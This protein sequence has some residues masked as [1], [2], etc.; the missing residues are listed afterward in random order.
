MTKRTRR[1]AD[2]TKRKKVLHDGDARQRP[3]TRSSGHCAS[4]PQQTT[5]NQHA[6]RTGVPPGWETSDQ[7]IFGVAHA[8]RKRGVVVGTASS[9]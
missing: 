1:I 8:G 4:V 2:E 7:K 3:V 6:R 9:L 5:K